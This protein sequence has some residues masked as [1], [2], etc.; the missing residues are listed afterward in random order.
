MKTKYIVLLFILVTGSF[1]RLSK[2][3]TIPPALFY[4][5]IDSGYQAMIF[6][7]NLTDYYGNK[8]PI[9]FKS[10]GDYR[11]SLPIYFT[12]LLQ[13]LSFNPELSIRLSSSILSILTILIF[14]LLTKSLISALLLS[15]S[16]WA[17]H[18]GRI[19]F[20]ASSMMFFILLGIYFW[21]KFI[22]QKIYKYLYLSLVIFTL[23]IYTYS[24]S[25]LFLIFIFLSLLIIWHKDIFKFG[26]KKLLLPTLLVLLLISPMI[27]DTFSGKTGFRFSYIGI[28]TLPHREQIV[29]SLRY[30]DALTDHPG[31]IGITTGFTSKL[32]HNKYQ[33]VVNKFINNYL[34]SFSTNFLFLTGDQ[35]PRHG[36]GNYGLLNIFDLLFVP[37]GLFIFFKKFSQNKL[38]QLFL[39]LLILSPIPF[40]LTRD[41][42]SPHSTRLILMLPSLLF[43][44]AR[45]LTFISNISRKLFIIILITY[46]LSFGCFWHYY[47]Y[48]YPQ[49]SARFWDVGMKEVVL[50]TKQYPNQIILFSDSYL[51]FV[52]DFLFYKPYLLDK[53]DLISN[54][55]KEYNNSFIS[56]Q[57]LDNKYYFGHI[58]WGNITNAPNTIAVV[59]KSEFETNNL[60]K[61]SILKIFSKKYINHEEFYLINLSQTN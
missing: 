24:T 1:L 8:F 59:T 36:F 27:Y 56:G 57:T 49:E 19:G 43:F 42:I 9:H 32:F 51:S 48:H 55:L 11:T 61:F 18:Y 21:K 14:F 15:I 60:S 16:P 50:T 47:K 26:I 34:N 44:S 23:S 13:K 39:Y 12:A 7:K 33:L 38:S 29:D 40:S 54:H 53:G 6:N 10:F 58:N 2:L 3:T 52:S 28:F 5:E 35:N 37:F 45:G 31:E 25:K 20:E 41:T 4:D 22:D 46:L 30:Q 17:I